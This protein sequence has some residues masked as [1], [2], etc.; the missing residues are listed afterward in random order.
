MWT[1]K[2]QSG[3]NKANSGHQYATTAR[4][5]A[6]HDAHAPWRADISHYLKCNS[7]ALRLVA[8]SRC[9]GAPTLI[10]PAASVF[11]SQR[12]SLLV[13]TPANRVST[14]DLW[15]QRLHHNHRNFGKLLSTPPTSH[16]FLCSTLQSSLPL[17]DL[18][19]RDGSTRD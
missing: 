7:N 17:T 12:R 16:G 11:T 1:P 4:F 14:V 18:G 5:S 15:I 9:D 2:L 10:V 8:L 3:Y 13:E 19:L 6:S